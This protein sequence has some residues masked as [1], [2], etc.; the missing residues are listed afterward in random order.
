MYVLTQGE[1]PPRGLGGSRVYVLFSFMM[2]Q[3]HEL[4]SCMYEWV[5]VHSVHLK[6]DNVVTT[7]LA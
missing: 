7:E 1:F 6:I 5:M 4:T 2:S 3:N